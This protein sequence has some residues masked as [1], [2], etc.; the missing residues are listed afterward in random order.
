M[1][2][3]KEAWVDFLLH[4]VFFKR[5]NRWELEWFGICAVN[6]STPLKKSIPYPNTWRI[7][8]HENRVFQVF[9]SVNW[10]SQYRCI[11]DAS[12]TRNKRD[13]HRGNLAALKKICKKTKKIIE[14]YVQFS[15]IASLV[16]FSS[17]DSCHLD[18]CEKKAV[19]TGSSVQGEAGLSE[20]GWFNN[21]SHGSQSCSPLF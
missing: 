11:L 1:Q 15:P 18:W 3:L 6:D 8:T 2:M 16:N 17:W 13:S 12:C 14:T 5:W 20:I 7:P 10:I 19:S 4:L 21:N 9:F